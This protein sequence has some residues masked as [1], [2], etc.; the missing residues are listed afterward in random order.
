MKNVTIIVDDSLFRHQLQKRNKELGSKEFLTTRMARSKSSRNAC[1]FSWSGGNTPVL[2]ISYLIYKHHQKLPN[3][4]RPGLWWLSD[5]TGKKTPA[6]SRP[7]SS[8]AIMMKLLDTCL[9]PSLVECWLHVLFDS[10]FPASRCR[11]TVSFKRHGC[12][13]HIVKRPD[14]ASSLAVNQ[15]LV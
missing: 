3:I 12:R 15:L 7:S 2:N 9:P 4:H 10:W 1:R 8:Q 11:S 5:T 14:S 6:C 13:F